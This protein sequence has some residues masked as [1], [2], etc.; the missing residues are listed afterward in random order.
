MGMGIK[1]RPA[2]IV[3]S[4]LIVT[5]SPSHEILIFYWRTAHRVVLPRRRDKLPIA[6]TLFGQHLA[7]A[8]R[9]IGTSNQV[10]QRQHELIRKQEANGRFFNWARS[11]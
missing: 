7:E 11:R 9:H 2:L 4:P 10:I 5:K 1:V 8:E 6:H 3:R